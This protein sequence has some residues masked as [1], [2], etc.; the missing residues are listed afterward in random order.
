MNWS[1]FWWAGPVLQLSAV[2]YFANCVRTGCKKKSHRD[3]L[4]LAVFVS[5]VLCAIAGWLV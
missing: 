2:L 3:G 4:L 1:I 5:I